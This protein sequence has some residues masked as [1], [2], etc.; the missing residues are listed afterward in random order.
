MSMGRSRDYSTASA[1]YPAVSRWKSRME[2]SSRRGAPSTSIRE[3]QIGAATWWS[4]PLSP[5]VADLV[6]IVRG[7][8]VTFWSSTSQGGG[9]ALILITL[10][11]IFSFILH[12]PLLV[13]WI[14]SEGLGEWR[15]R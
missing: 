6:C 14:N 9:G 4:T 15:S 12:F 10:N 8:L 1:T 7:C 2:A 5:S 3:A 11:R 13:G